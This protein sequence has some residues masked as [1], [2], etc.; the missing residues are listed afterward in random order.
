M[1]NAGQ[2]FLKTRK[3]TFQIQHAT[4]HSLLFYISEMSDVSTVP[5]SK[6]R[7]QNVVRST[8]M[9]KMSQIVQCGHS[10]ELYS[11]R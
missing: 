4:R 9:G 2:P 7:E 3:K 1:K 10:T 5:V 8:E 6:A 11:L